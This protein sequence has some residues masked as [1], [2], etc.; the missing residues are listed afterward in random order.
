M[1]PKLLVLDTFKID[2]KYVSH[3]SYIFMCDKCNK[4]VTTTDKKENRCEKCSKG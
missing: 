4:I 3:E 1:R 2:D